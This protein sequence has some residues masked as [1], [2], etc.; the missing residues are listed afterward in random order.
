MSKTAFH[1]L[2]AVVCTALITLSSAHGAI[3]I[4]GVLDE[5]EWADAR[6][7]RDF[8][9]VEPL[10]VEPAK[11][12]TEARVIVNAEGIFVGFSNYQPATVKRVE[13]YFPRDTQIDAD[14]NVVSIDFDGTALAGYDFTVGSAN[15]Q[16]DGIVTKGD[17][18]ADWDGTW[19]SQI[20]STGDYW[21]SEM[22]IPWSVAPMTAAKEGRKTMGLWFSRVVFDESLRFAFPDAY[23]SRTTFMEDWHQIEVAQVAASTLEWFPYISYSDN[24]FDG[25]ETAGDTGFKLAWTLFGGPTVIPN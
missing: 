5:P 20:S 9:T 18:S 21:Y 3:L 4:D 25:A 24:L 8:V 16:Q 15:S 6:V 11:Y 7:Y 12:R 17:Y 2:S 14:R 1:Y 22:H 23:Y 19:Y 13:R 10:T